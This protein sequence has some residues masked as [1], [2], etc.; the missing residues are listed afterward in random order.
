MLFDWKWDD[1][2]P[3][4]Q[5]IEGYPLQVAIGA[6][7]YIILNSEHS[8][9]SCGS[10][11]RGQLGIGNNEDQSTLTKINGVNGNIIH[12]ACGFYH[13]MALMSDGGVYSWGWNLYGQLGIG[14]S[15]SQ[16][17]PTPITDIP[18]KVIQIHCGAYFSM[19]LT[20][21]GSLYSWGYSGNGELG[22]GTVTDQLTPKRVIGISNIVQFSCGS[23]SVMALSKEG[24]V[25][26]WGDNK[27]GQLGIQDKGSHLLPIRIYS[28]PA[29]ID[30]IS[31]GGYHTMVLLRDGSLY[32]LG[33]NLY[34]QLGNGSRESEAV[35]IRIDY[36]S[37]QKV[38]AIQGGL[39]QSMAITSN[40]QLYYWGGIENGYKMR[41][42]FVYQYQN[43][44]QKLCFE[45]SHLDLISCWPQSHKLFS[46]K[47][48]KLVEEI[49]L[50]LQTFI[51]ID[52]SIHFIQRL[53]H[54]LLF[55]T[56]CLPSN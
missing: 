46:Q 11:D 35:P 34:G 42:I 13:S 37:S 6:D 53:L 45:R 18:T 8:L 44:N 52:I 24:D 3:R 27:H 10:N 2:T 33:N 28:F 38:I 43:Q 32:C 20:K 54:E 49:L 16:N 47:I 25:Y 48:Q 40:Y 51:P 26:G 41:Q 39:W 14:N 50:I 1:M 30:Q 56:K 29:N 4:R 12:I 19:A 55:I 23:I 31:C 36:F 9:F 21:E 15:E 22:V 7:H 17:L 5:Y